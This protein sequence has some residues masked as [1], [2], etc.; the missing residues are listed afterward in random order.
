MADVDVVVVSYNSADGLRANVDPLSRLSNVHVIVVDNG[1]SDGSLD[2]VAD[3][4]VTRLQ[5]A[6]DGFAA[7]CNA[8]WRAGAAPYVLFLNPDARIG[9]DA[10]A[11]LHDV[12]EQNAEVGIVGPRIVTGDGSLDYSQRRFPRLRSTYARALLLHR[13]LPHA[14]W[15][16]EIV[17]DDVAYEA[18]RPAEWLSGACLLVR[19]SVLEELG[20]WD[21]GFFMYCEDKDLCKRAWDAGRHVRYEPSATCVHVGGASAP[22]SSLLPVLAASRLRYAAKHAGTAA[23]FLERL[24]LALE[25]GI[26]VATARGGGSKRAGHARSLRVLAGRKPPRSFADASHIASLSAASVI[27]AD[28]D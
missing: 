2:S 19:R 27:P 9:R 8:G 18:R 4:P 24:G 5:R 12:L 17:R 28:R 11:A 21:E 23:A 10:V 6:N 16:D 20:G 22:R 14:R 13:V 26:R 25:A 7:G 3:L 1:S 15:T